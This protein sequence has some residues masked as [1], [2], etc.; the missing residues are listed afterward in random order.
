MIAIFFEKLAAF[1]SRVKDIPNFLPFNPECRRS[2]PL[3]KAVQYLPNLTLSRPSR[4]YRLHSP[5][6]ESSSLLGGGASCSICNIR[7]YIL[8]RGAHHFLPLTYFEM[9]RSRERQFIFVT[10]ITAEVNCQESKNLSTLSAPYY[11][12]FN[13]KFIFSWQ[14]RGLLEGNL[15]RPHQIWKKQAYTCRVHG[16]RNGKWDDFILTR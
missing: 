15:V 8:S 9:L 1:I 14:S 4:T 7:V 13:S 2:T 16:R 10:E 5:P 6:W 3:L 11:K 12:S